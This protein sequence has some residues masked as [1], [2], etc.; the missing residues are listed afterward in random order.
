M[1]GTGGFLSPFPSLDKS[2]FSQDLERVLQRSLIAEMMAR[3]I[4]IF[5]DPFPSVR[6]YSSVKTGF[7]LKT[8]F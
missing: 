1:N 4:W 3:E 7:Q 2:V 6:N 5:L 8:S